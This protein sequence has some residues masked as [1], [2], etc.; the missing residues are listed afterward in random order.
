LSG[1]RL[2]AGVQRLARWQ[3]IARMPDLFAWTRCSAPMSGTVLSLQEG[4]CFYAITAQIEPLS[5][6]RA[7]LLDVS[8]VSCQAS[9][10]RMY[11][12]LFTVVLKAVK[13]VEVEATRPTS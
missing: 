7:I 8:R 1:Q 4:I 11:I 3:G 9:L 12:S 6:H 5:G 2:A 10:W 13:L